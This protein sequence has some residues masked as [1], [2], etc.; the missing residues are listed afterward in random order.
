MNKI[1]VYLICIG[2]IAGIV[3]A[4]CRHDLLEE[5]SL[6]QEAELWQ[7]MLADPIF[8]ELGQLIDSRKSME[9]LEKLTKDVPMEDLGAVIKQNIY[10]QQQIVKEYT[11]TLKQRYPEFSDRGFVA[12]CDS[13]NNQPKTK[14]NLDYYDE[15]TVL[16]DCNLSA[17]VFQDIL[18]YIQEIKAAYCKIYPNI[19]DL[20]FYAM[21][22]QGAVVKLYE[23]ERIAVKVICGELMRGF[24]ANGCYRVSEIAMNIRNK[25]GIYLT[26][27]RKVLRVLLFKVKENPQR[28]FNQP[29]GSDGSSGSDNNN[30]QLQQWI[31]TFPLSLQPIVEQILKAFEKNGL[32]ISH[33][34]SKVNVQFATLTDGNLAEIRFSAPPGET[35]FKQV[36]MQLILPPFS[37]DDR[38]LLI[39]THELFHLA[40]FDITWTAGDMVKL[41]QINPILAKYL[42]LGF[43]VDPHH[44]YIGRIVTEYEYILRD[45][46]PGKPEEFYTY[47]KWGGGITDSYR[48]QKLPLAEQDRIKKY[49]KDH[50]LL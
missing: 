35:Y 36:P 31:K 5:D 43:G 46:F 12:L 38:Y 45:A 15:F 24:V 16:G 14:G 1:Y 6:R 10:F 29:N 40:L 47:G 22:S 25:N 41:M 19:S 48:F 37:K 49:L 7:S 50:N 2:M 28:N 42:D 13:V 30:S 9:E 33:V 3:L 8:I 4:G 39:V 44:E 27:L 17:A 34:I 32:D 20:T 18:I 23:N 26:E 11:V 21:L